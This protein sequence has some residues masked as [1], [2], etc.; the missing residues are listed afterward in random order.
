MTREAV[1]EGLSFCSASVYPGGVSAGHG[2]HIVR[3]ISHVVAPCGSSVCPT[4]LVV[5]LRGKVNAR[6]FLRSLSTRAPLCSAAAPGVCSGHVG[7]PEEDPTVSMTTCVPPPHLV[8]AL[9]LQ[10]PVVSNDF[11]L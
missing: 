2:D 6:C 11:R 5:L 10:D 1:G 8:P 4:S 3:D 9:I 7:S